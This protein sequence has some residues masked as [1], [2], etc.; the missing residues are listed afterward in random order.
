[1]LTLPDD[2]QRFIV[3]CDMSIVGLGCVLMQKGKFIAYAAMLLMIQDKNYLSHDL[4]FDAVEFTFKIW[5]H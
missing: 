2:R 3:Y 1:M 5:H 4:E